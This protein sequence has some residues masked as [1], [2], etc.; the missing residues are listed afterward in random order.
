MSLISVFLRM[1][2]RKF[3]QST[4]RK[5]E[6]RKRREKK[7]EKQAQQLPPI[8]STPC[9][10]VTVPPLTVS[11]PIESYFG[12]C[13]QS[14]VA[15][16]LRLTSLPL[17]SSWIIASTDPLT[18]CKMR[19]HQEGQANVTTTISIDGELG[20]TVFFSGKELTPTSCPLLAKLPHK[21]D[22]VSL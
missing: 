14:S 1:G 22:S 5:N 17:P 18:L 7:E 2:G 19:L 15:L 6:E 16:H 13:V 11:L 3:R 4:H 9:Q 10:P 8:V 12:G 20:W 21:L